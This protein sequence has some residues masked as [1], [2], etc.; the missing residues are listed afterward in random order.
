MNNKI[1]KRAGLMV[2]V[3]GLNYGL[4]RITKIL[5]M[6]YLRGRDALVFL[7][8]LFRLEYAENSGAFLSLGSS[9]PPAVK[10]VLL[11]G[12]PLA[13]CLYALWHCLFKEVRTSWAL[14]ITTIVA[15]GFGNLQDRVFNGFKVVDFMNFGI[16][17]LR[18][19]IL[20]VGDMSVT[21]GAIALALVIYLAERRGEI[22]TGRNVKKS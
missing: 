5:A 10:Y 17:N 8:N 14:L 4:D 20:N 16:G 9:W 18:T 7:H 13:V 19:G 12:L 3:F 1:W 2:L 6:T 22:E 21:F 15:G 11:G